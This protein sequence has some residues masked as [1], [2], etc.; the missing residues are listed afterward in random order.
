MDKRLEGGGEDGDLFVFSPLSNTLE[1]GE[2][3][4]RCGG[5]CLDL[6]HREVFLK[7]AEIFQIEEDMQTKHIIELQKKMVILP[8]VGFF[9]PL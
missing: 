5:Q 2:S 3:G 7:A 9:S 1:R 8:D 4:H 6:L